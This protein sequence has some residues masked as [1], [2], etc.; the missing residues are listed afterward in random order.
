M[1]SRNDYFRFEMKKATRHLQMSG[2]RLISKDV[3][4]LR[5]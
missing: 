4:A 5:S 3:V 1:A 2:R